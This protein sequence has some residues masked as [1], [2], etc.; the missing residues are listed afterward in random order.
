MVNMS[1]VGMVAVLFR[2]LPPLAAPIR[3]YPSEVSQLGH[4]LI[5]SERHGLSVY[6]LL[7]SPDFSQPA[8]PS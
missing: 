1:E 5:S 4:L 6:L 8:R 3:N 2:P 7:P